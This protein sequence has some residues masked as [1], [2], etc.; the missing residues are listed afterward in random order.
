MLRGG[1]ALDFLPSHKTVLYLFPVDGKTHVGSGPCGT[2]NPH[3]QQQ[4]LCRNKQKHQ[5][6]KV[7]N[8]GNNEIL[9]PPAKL[10]R[11]FLHVLGFEGSEV[12]S[13]DLCEVFLGTLVLHVQNV[14]IRGG[15][16]E[17]N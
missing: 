14:L 11:G 16:I 1:L 6:L 8:R 10:P 7:A 13:I 17:L 2:P 9:Q 5:L 3:Y 4:N 15:G 12:F